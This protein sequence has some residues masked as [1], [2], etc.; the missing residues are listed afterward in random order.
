VRRLRMQTSRWAWPPLGRKPV[1]GRV[2]EA[3]LQLVKRIWYQNPL[4]TLMRGVFIEENGGTRVLCCFGVHPF[5]TTM[6]LLMLGFVLLWAGIFAIAALASLVAENGPIKGVAWLGLA[7]PP[8]AVGLGVAMIKFGR[9]LARHEQQFL[10]DFL[11]HVIEARLVYGPAPQKDWVASG[12][13]TDLR[14]WLPGFR[15]TI[16]NPVSRPLP[17]GERAAALHQG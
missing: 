11:R 12:R 2:G 4:Q 15:V 8:L 6:L 10:I 13:S 16:S 9:F 17:R 1:T 7:V 5:V 14:N 3:S